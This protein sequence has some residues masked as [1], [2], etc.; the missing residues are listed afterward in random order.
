MSYFVRPFQ[1]ES[2]APPR[3]PGSFRLGE[4]APNAPVDLEIGCGVGWHPIRYAGANPGRRL[5]A[6]E[7]TRAK[8]ESFQGRLERHAPLAN[9]LAVHA[10]AVRWVSHHLEPASIDRCFLLY[11]NPEPRAANKRW[12]RSP[13]MHRLLETLKPGGE[14]LLATNEKPYF[15][16]ALEWGERAWGLRIAET[17]RFDASSAPDDTPRTHFEKKYLAAGQ[18]CF[19]VRFVKP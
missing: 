3:E 11:P 14:L 4:W 2:V 17:R 13:F 6:I 5:I 19:D 8:F 10:D 7:H 12:L 1:L 9:L 16:E 15:E 18:T